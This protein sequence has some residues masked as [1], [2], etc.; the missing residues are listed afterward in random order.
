MNV[1]TPTLC[2]SERAKRRMAWRNERVLYE[3]KCSA[4]GADLISIYPPNTPF[5]VYDNKYWWGDSW[6]A[7]DYAMDFDFSKPF[8]EQFKTLLNKVPRPHTSVTLDS[9]VNSLYCNEAANLKNCYLVF[10]A[11]FSEDCMFCDHTYFCRDCA[12]CSNIK[13]SE[14]CYECMYIDNCYDCKYVFNGI[15]AVEC[16]FCYDVKNCNNCFGCVNLRNKQYCFMNVQY[17]KDEYE[18]KLKD[19]LENNTFSELREHFMKYILSFPAKHLMITMSEDCIGDHI[20]YSKNVKDSFNVTESEDCRYCDIISGGAKK[21]DLYDVLTGY[22]GLHH[23]YDSHCLG[24]S[25]QEVMFSDTCDG[26]S[27]LQYCSFCIGCQDCFGCVG[28]RKQQYCIL[29][30]QYSKEDYEALKN[31]II[32]HMQATGEY[33]E[34][35]PIDISPFC[36][37]ETVAH[38]YYPMTQE[39][40]INAGYRWQESLSKAYNNG[41]NY[42]IPDKIS[43]VKDDILDAILTCEVSQKNYNIKPFELKY[44]RKMGIPIPRKHPDIRHLER[45][46]TRNPRVLYDTKC[47]HC[48]VN[49]T[50][51][52]AP[53]AHRT[54]LCEAC[55]E[56]CAA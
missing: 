2:P 26:S 35:F 20:S 50:T 49:L 54:I 22:Y 33:G 6:D 48:Q 15:R 17:T 36:Y 25:S 7:K 38:E 41:T 31:K 43:D 30:K 11:N 28:L 37:N 23:C 42:T 21:H 46:N 18:M 55:F 45:L 14:L 19:V 10:E 51:T 4:T 40:C 9:M 24:N 29:N 16:L 47:A 5:P 56:K 39:A 1:P 12:D 13:N 3:R 53:E 27:N 52:Y 34:F 8:F 32:A 44:Y